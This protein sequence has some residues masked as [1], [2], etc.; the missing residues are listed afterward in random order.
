MG[1]KR[2]VT[3]KEELEKMTEEELKAFIRKQHRR[4][5]CRVNQQRYRDRQKQQETELEQAMKVLNSK[6]NRASSFNQ[7]LKQGKVKDP[8]HSNQ[9]RS[10]ISTM[11]ADMFD[12][13]V[14]KTDLVLYKKQESF[15]KFNFDENVV[16]LSEKFKTGLTAMFEQWSLYTTLHHQFSMKKISVS[17]DDPNGNLFRVT[18]EMAFVISYRTIANLYPHMLLDHDFLEKVIGKKLAFNCHQFLQF[19]ENNQ[20]ATIHADYK[21][22][23]AWF[24]LLGDPVLAARVV[25][26]KKIDHSCYITADVESKEFYE[27]ESVSSNNSSRVMEIDNLLN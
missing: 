14:D 16:V 23:Q 25:G 3:S 15:A 1:R 4:D 9:V 27:P 11:Y 19:D 24:K 12:F 8:C 2:K 13:G 22:I 26:A 5:L 17:Q 10:L 21:M 20:V 18:T 7:L 6:I